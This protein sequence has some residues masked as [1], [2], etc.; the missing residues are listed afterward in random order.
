MNSS[1]D[2]NVYRRLLR[3]STLASS[4]SLI[5]GKRKRPNNTYRLYDRLLQLVDK[6]DASGVAEI[7]RLLLERKSA[8]PLFSP[9][10]KIHYT[11]L[12]RH[13]TLPSKRNIRLGEDKT[14]MRVAVI[15]CRKRN[16]SQTSDLLKS[17]F[18]IDSILSCDVDQTH[19][20]SNEFT[21]EFGCG[22]LLSTESGQQSV[23][24]VLVFHVVGD[25]RPLW[26]F[27]MRFSEYL[28]I[29]D[30]SKE[31]DSLQSSFLET[32][33]QNLTSQ[34]ILTSDLASIANVCL[35][36]PSVSVTSY[37]TK[38]AAD[39]EFRYFYIEGQLGHNIV[40]VLRISLIGA[41]QEQQS[42]SNDHKISLH[43]MPILQD[44]D[45]SALPCSS[46]DEIE[47]SLAEITSSLGEIKKKL[48]ALFHRL[49]LIKDPSQ[50][51][52]SIRMFEKLLAEQSLRE[53]ESQLLNTNHQTK[54]Q[55][56]N[57]AI[58]T[59]VKE[60]VLNIEHLWREMNDLTVNLTRRAS[61]SSEITDTS[62]LAAQHLL[63][64]FC[65]ELLDGDSDSIHVDWIKEVLH[66][67]SKL[68][69]RH[70]KER[71][72]VLSVVGVQSSGKSTLL[73]TMF[74]VQLRT[75]VGQCTR[76][77]NMQLLAVEGRPEYDYILLLDTEGTRAPEYYGLPGS[78]KRDNKMATLS[79]LLSDATIVVIPGEND[80]AIKEILPVV[81]MA[82]QGSKLAES[83]GGQ[84]S[85][86]MFFVYNR[87]DTTQKEKLNNIIQTLET[88]LNEA[89]DLVQRLKG[90]AV[91]KKDSP[92]RDFKLDASNPSKSDVY[93][94][95]NAKKEFEPPNDV[96]S[97]A[98]GEALA[99]LREHIHQRVTSYSNGS[100]WKGRSIGEFSRYVGEVWCCICSADFT[101]SFTSVMERFNFDK[102]E[103]AFKTV[104]EKLAECY[105]INFEILK[106]EMVE[107]QGKLMIS[108]GTN[109]REEEENLL[110]SFDAMLREKIL[111]VEVVLDEKMKLIV[112]K[113]GREKWSIQFQERW[114][115]SK[116]EQSQNWSSIMKTSFTTLFYLEH[117]VENFKKKMRIEIG[118]F[119]KS[120][121]Q[122]T[123]Q[124]KKERKLKKFDSLYCNI[125]TEAVEEFPDLDV[126]KEIGK[127]YQ[128]SSV[129]KTRQVDFKDEAIHSVKP[130]QSP[131]FQ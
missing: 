49:L 69:G 64:G 71:I 106:K 54:N 102:T 55:E 58:G 23:K 120:T 36:K 34:R 107:Y 17:L 112:N 41:C 19:W 29:E 117:H 63:D 32:D 35:W 6:F 96:P 33:N 68:I 56:N 30:T 111:P 12:L 37:E 21:A 78:E 115:I 95:G 13:I 113:K 10:S 51:F 45:F 39:C 77:V 61:R 89:F 90:D 108:N 109:N 74:G 86:M 92:F 22:C 80:A 2:Q 91:E 31:K 50:R 53:S 40:Q 110:K 126:V 11:S 119:F 59:R 3:S 14:L 131:T 118:A 116:L 15:S 9:S 43:E 94:L 48:V 124:W 98:F 130:T 125:L 83:N 72:F 16:E 20:I 7:F 99:K 38:E 62:R 93:I 122:R 87:I 65:L 105:R 82:Y 97:A 24:D 88:S 44:Y 27:I 127:V 8:I 67:L 47:S 104:E 26:P 18:H 103:F 100:S 84:L 128:E 121:R 129:I 81:K 57:G 123:S 25:F 114:R 5:T 66:Q 46:P 70:N 79:I 42:S 73:N 75:S 85:S 101:L 4:C 52:L 28:L 76:G 1:D 60:S